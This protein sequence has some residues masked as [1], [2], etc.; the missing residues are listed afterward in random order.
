MKTLYSLS[1]GTLPPNLLGKLARIVT[2]LCPGSDLVIPSDLV[3]TDWGGVH[4]LIAGLKISVV[5]VE[6]SVIPSESG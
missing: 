3:E 4:V 6:Q 2:Q 5:R 1:A